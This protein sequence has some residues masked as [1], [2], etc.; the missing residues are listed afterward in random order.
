M[1]STDRERFEELSGGY[2]LGSL[3]SEEREELFQ[4]AQSNP[5]WEKELQDLIHLDS[6]MKE[7]L[8]PGR[9][10]RPSLLDRLLLSN[11]R[12]SR[13]LERAHRYR[14]R[15]RKEVGIG[16]AVAVAAGLA[17][18]FY[19]QPFTGRHRSSQAKLQAALGNCVAAGR[20]L[21]AGESIHGPLIASGTESIC[22]LA[23]DENG[24]IVVR[25]NPETTVQLL[26]YGGRGH[27]LKLDRG[28]MLVDARSRLNN[29][30]D[31]DGQL[32]LVMDGMAF[33]IMTN[34]AV[35]E[36]MIHG[37]SRLDVMHG[38]V[39]MRKLEHDPSHLKEEA[40]GLVEFAS[41]FPDDSSPEWIPEGMSY[42]RVST[43]DGNMER[44]VHPIPLQRRRLLERNFRRLAREMEMEMRGIPLQIPRGKLV[45]VRTVRGTTI[46]ARMI[47]NEGESI[48]LATSHG[49]VRIPADQ[50]VHLEY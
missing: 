20:A 11:D 9:P 38:G 37:A 45:H 5:L 46:E 41:D 21:R 29:G 3:S 22:D 30:G 39:R 43:T 24:R 1:N 36:R 48:L 42:R 44:A 27:V 32:I 50:I 25:L 13:G 35:A 2:M 19:V 6:L 14:V 34:R 7:S 8:Q 4:L 26:P 12:I 40:M 28:R 49:S 47:R 33:Q 31:E 17:I 15:N 18:F 10:Y 16:S 23:L